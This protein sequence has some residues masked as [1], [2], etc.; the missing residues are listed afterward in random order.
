MRLT[1]SVTGLS[2]LLRHTSLFRQNQQSITY[3][4]NFP[5]PFFYFAP[6]NPQLMIFL[7][8]SATVSLLHDLDRLGL[9]HQGN[10]DMPI[11][12]GH[13]Y[14][15]PVRR[16][17][18]Q[19]PTRRPGRHSNP[20]SEGTVSLSFGPDCI[21]PTTPNHP[22]PH[23]LI[24]ITH[25]SPTDPA[26][27]DLIRLS[28]RPLGLK[29]QIARSPRHRTPGSVPDSPNRSLLLLPHHHG[30]THPLLLLLRARR[31]PG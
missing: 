5:P 29:P 21:R 12:V 28:T 24:T 13:P 10:A 20:M 27:G 3:F 30:P 6:E 17:G 16:A 14:P 8:I 26:F 31:A 9:L 11:H 4:K 22:V 1:C 19:V 7:F 2:F 23:H 18:L 15:S 25:H